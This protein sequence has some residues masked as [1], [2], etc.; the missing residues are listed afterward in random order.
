MR[1]PKALSALMLALMLAWPGLSCAAGAKALAKATLAKPNRVAIIYVQPTDPAHQPIYELLRQHRVLERFQAYLSPLRLPQT[2]R[3]RTAGCD[4]EDNAWYEEA[5]REVTVCYE[6]IDAVQRNAPAQTTAAGISPQDA[7]LGP[8]IEVFLHEIAH[9]LF[10]L[11]DLP[12]LGREE[13]AADQIAAYMMLQLDRDMARRTVAAVAR[14]Y[15]REASSQ[16][17]AQEDLADVHGLS[18]Q[19]LYNL[20]CMAYGDDPELFADAVAIGRLPKERAEGC[21]DEYLQ[22]EHAFN[23]LIRPHIDQAV[24]RKL[25]RARLLAPTTQRQA[26]SWTKVQ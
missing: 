4:G 23:Q 25:D 5:D 8:G 14:M 22:V 16:T 19:R 12:I 20:L 6:Y 3:L 7:V 9:A 17:V 21:I 13:D 15:R 1:L 11:L 26:P 24:K 18:G 10:H 2:L